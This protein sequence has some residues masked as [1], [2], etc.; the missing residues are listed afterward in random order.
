MD[1]AAAVRRFAFRRTLQVNHVDGLTYD[2]LFGMA[3]T[4]ADTGE[5]VLDLAARWNKPI[6]QKQ[7]D[8]KA[9]EHYRTRFEFYKQL[10]PA[11]KD[12][13]LVL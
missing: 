6:S 9:A 4:L 1:K 8:P 3:K 5:L 12:L 10:Y 13:S 2:Y 7:P 11:L